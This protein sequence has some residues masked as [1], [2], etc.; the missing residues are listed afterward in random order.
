MMYNPRHF[1]TA[2]RMFDPVFE[3]FTL[4][5]NKSVHYSIKKH[6]KVTF[7]SIGLDTNNQGHNIEDTL[8]SPYQL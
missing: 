6:T 4:N 8:R 2:G 1:L 5:D 3:M 7:R